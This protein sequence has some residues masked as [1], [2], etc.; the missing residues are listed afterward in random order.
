MF[1]NQAIAQAVN[2]TASQQTNNL[3]SFLPLILIFAV[4]YFLIVRPQ[5]KKMK[6]HQNM[7]NNLKAGD[8]VVTAG[9][10]IGLVKS[11]KDDKVEI[12]IA[13]DVK[14]KVVKNYVTSLVQNKTK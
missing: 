14:I 2:E 10:L 9:G 4:F 5:S 11:V 6:E 3:M 8:E 1:I 13:D 7:V 12:E